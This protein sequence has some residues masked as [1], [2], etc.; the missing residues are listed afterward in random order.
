MSTSRNRSTYGAPR[1]NK[2]PFPKSLATVLDTLVDLQV[3]NVTRYQA[4]MANRIIP[5]VD[6]TQLVHSMI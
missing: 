1:T 3:S 4:A 5:P 6:N 2:P